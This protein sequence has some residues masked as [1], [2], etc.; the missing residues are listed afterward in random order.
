MGEA[1]RAKARLAERY[2]QWPWPFP[3]AT[4]TAAQLQVAAAAT[5][6]EKA[7]QPALAGKDGKP[8]SPSRQQLRRQPRVPK[9]VL[10]EL[11][12]KVTKP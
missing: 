9:S 3:A 12:K 4:M 11:D 2:G 7:R 8:S 6:D 5:K 10:A 1:T